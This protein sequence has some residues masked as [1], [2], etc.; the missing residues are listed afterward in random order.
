MRPTLVR[1][2]GEYVRNPLIAARA[3]V[4]TR[5]RLRNDPELNVLV[6]SQ[7][8]WSWLLRCT[9]V[10]PERH[11]S[12]SSPPNMNSAS[13]RWVPETAW[14]SRS[15]APLCRDTALAAEFACRMMSGSVTLRKSLHP[16][17]GAVTA[18]P[19]RPS[20]RRT[21]LT[22]YRVMVPESLA[23]GV[24]RWPLQNPTLSR[25]VQ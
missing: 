23:R 10:A 9:N 16:N 13:G 8:R 22:E 20:T 4:R 14:A 5:F 3:W 12:G 11:S 15:T 19:R 25:N 18:R 21:G 2:V 7:C 17:S 6:G 1:G 24:V